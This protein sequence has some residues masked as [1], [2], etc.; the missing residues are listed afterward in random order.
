MALDVASEMPR[1]GRR[2]G[3]VFAAMDGPAPPAREPFP[4]CQ[5]GPG[6]HR[7]ALPALAKR[8]KIGPLRWQDSRRE[9]LA[10]LL[11]L[12]AAAGCGSKIDGSTPPSDGGAPTGCG[13]I[14]CPPLTEC[15]RGACVS[16]DPCRDVGCDRGFVCSYGT[17]VNPALDEDGDGA[18]VASDCDDRD[19]DVGPGSTAPCSTECGD[20]TTTCSDGAWGPCSAPLDCSCQAGDTRVEPCGRCGSA[21]RSCG[22]DGRWGAVGACANEGECLGG[23]IEVGPCERGGACSQRERTCAPDCTWGAW[24]ACA[25][26]SECTP[27][28]VDH[29]DCGNC[30]TQSRTC[31]DQCL[32]SALSVCEEGGECP[33]GEVE[34]EACDTCGTRSRTCSAACSW[35]AWSACRGGACEQGAVETRPCG[36][37]GSQSRTCA[38]DCTWG[39]WGGCGGE[40]AC[41][42]GDQQT[43]DCDC[44]TETRT[45]AGGC[46]WGGWAGCPGA[47]G[48]G[49]QCSGGACQCGPFPHWEL[50]GGQCRPSCGVALAD[51]VLHNDGAGCCP[52]GCAPGRAETE[53]TRDCAHCCENWLGD[54][55]N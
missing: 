21:T 51:A 47:C 33:A 16:V 24:G 42:A 19:P 36:N 34:Q 30:G 2:P 43:R 44:G 14:Q 4:L 6:R 48:R 3:A 28:A 12:A 15:D 55:C 40:G 49:F 54:A 31:S 27:G 1:P 45:C 52:G 46:Q 7:R 10:V 23:A 18:P 41:A 38:A 11:A 50:V 29:L 25:D 26:G 9:A 37:C 20:G 22:R 35:Q 32:W 5:R 13:A 53:P 8:G 39:G 17:C